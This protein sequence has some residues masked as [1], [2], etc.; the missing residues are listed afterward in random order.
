MAYNTKKL[1]SA[2]RHKTFYKDSARAPQLSPATPPASYSSVI[3]DSAFCCPPLSPPRFSFSTPRDIFSARFYVVTPRFAKLITA[4]FITRLF[5][6]CDRRA[7][8]I[9][10]LQAHTSPTLNRI[11]LF[12]GLVKCFIG[13]SVR[14]YKTKA[15]DASA[16]V[17]CCAS[18]HSPRTYAPTIKK[19]SLRDYLNFLELKRLKS[20]R[21]YF[22]CTSRASKFTKSL[23]RF[24]EP[25]TRKIK[26]VMKTRFQSQ[27]SFF[28]INRF[29]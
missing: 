20:T 28:L 18:L 21:L 12:T 22:A 27:K 14:R 16:R 25:L 9:G 13:S 2:R 5:A 6:P 8:V 11:I 19:E 23:K 7:A 29:C 17:P 4:Y 24:Y 15:V 10:A 1:T 26:R 3:R